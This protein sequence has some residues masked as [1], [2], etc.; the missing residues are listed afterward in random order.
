MMKNYSC[1]SCNKTAI[2]FG[3]KLFKTKNSIFN[4]KS[5]GI[6]L[7]YDTTHGI[8][9]IIYAI[10]IW[11]GVTILISELRI[12]IIERQI[13][14]VGFCALM[15]VGISIVTPIKVYVKRIRKS[16]YASTFGV[17]PEELIKDSD[18]I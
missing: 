12:P 10:M 11:L 15:A 3:S 8:K 7:Q 17:K 14:Y 5:C 16:P 18:K 4:C 9:R 1:P 2:T 6:P 13:I